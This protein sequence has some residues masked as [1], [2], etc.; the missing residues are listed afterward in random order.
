M[1]INWYP[2]HMAKTKRQLQEQLN[3][4]D[5]VIELCDARLP[6]SSRNPDLEKLI[7]N[8]KRVL[9]LN[10][11]DLADPATTSAW[12]NY[13]RNQGIDCAPYNATTGKAKDALPIPLIMN[14]VAIKTTINAEITATFLSFKNFFIF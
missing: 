11:A 14:A 2:G 9:L 5:V 12:L 3:R 13:F 4:V 7:A 10:K 6:Y 8:K 1:D